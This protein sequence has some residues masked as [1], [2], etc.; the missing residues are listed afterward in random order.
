[1]SPANVPVCGSKSPDTLM[2]MAMPERN[3]RLS[4][5]RAQAVLAHLAKSGV[6]MARMSAVGYGT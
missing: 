4:E 6:P 3:Q 2:A 1:M 5:R